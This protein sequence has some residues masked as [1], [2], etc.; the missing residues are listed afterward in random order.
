M[1]RLSKAK[2]D[3]IVKLREDGYIQKEVAQ[4]VAVDIK[5]VRK[6]D[7]LRQSV[8]QPQEETP[9]LSELLKRID[10]IENA[11]GKMISAKRQGCLYHEIHYPDPEDE[12][13]AIS[14]C[15]RTYWEE[16]PEAWEAYYGKANAYHYGLEE[17]VIKLGGKWYKVVTPNQCTTCSLFY[18]K[19]S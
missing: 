6:Y 14:V 15:K 5:T 4:K 17:H 19:S 2:I 9:L 3:K 8:K 16:K 12:E 10:G 7:P 18:P 1:G 11:I 13:S